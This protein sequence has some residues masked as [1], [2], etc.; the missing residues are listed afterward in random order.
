[1]LMTMNASNI[2]AT[3]GEACKSMNMLGMAT[4]SVGVS[5]YSNILGAHEFASDFTKIVDEVSG[6]EELEKFV[7][8]PDFIA[9]KEEILCIGQEIKLL[10]EESKQ[11][12][13]KRSNS[14][15]RRTVSGASIAHVFDMHSNEGM[16]KDLD[17]KWSK[18]RL[19]ESQDSHESS[20]YSSDSDSSEHDINT[21]Q[22]RADELKKKRKFMMSDLR[23]RFKMLPDDKI[24]SIKSFLTVINKEII[25]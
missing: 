15:I 1:M 18:M 4:S 7:T 23:A 19:N 12:L 20:Q 8:D 11:K 24:S 17:A 5:D 13:M 9:A 14:S 3:V 2:H 6:F 16:F 25:S 10:E 21:L 22:N